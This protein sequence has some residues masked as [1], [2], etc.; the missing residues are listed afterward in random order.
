MQLK[1]GE[2]S[3]V[4]RVTFTVGLNARLRVL[5]VQNVQGGGGWGGGGVLHIPCRLRVAL[6]SGG[7]VISDMAWWMCCLSMWLFSVTRL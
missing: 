3:E 7:P 1:D 6:C 5:M 4:N 2:E